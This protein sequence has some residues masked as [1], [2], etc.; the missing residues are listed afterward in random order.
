MS[1]LNIVSDIKYNILYEEEKY[2]FDTQ[3]K[4]ILSFQGINFDI[5]GT[6]IS[7]LEVKSVCKRI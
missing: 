7:D 3:Y 6:K 1:Y 2:D 5:K 4:I